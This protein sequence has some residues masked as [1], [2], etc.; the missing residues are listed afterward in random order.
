MVLVAAI[1]LPLLLGA[2]PDLVTLALQLVQRMVTDQLLDGAEL[3][4]NVGRGSA[5]TLSFD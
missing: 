5:V 3:K 4:A 1:S 2:Q